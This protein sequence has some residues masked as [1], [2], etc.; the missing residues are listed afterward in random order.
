MMIAVA[1]FSPVAIAALFSPIAIAAPMQDVLQPA[2]PQA[3][4]IPRYGS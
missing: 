4:H 2:G 3:G 1:L